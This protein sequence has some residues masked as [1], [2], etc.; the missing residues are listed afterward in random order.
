MKK[1]ILLNAFAAFI[2]SL[3]MMSSALAQDI[4][5]NDGAT[6]IITNAGTYSNNFISTSA[7]SNSSAILQINQNLAVTFTGNLLVQT[8]TL[9]NIA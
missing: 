3:L 1:S 2:L 6:V 4:E 5:V 8:V 9:N 7:N